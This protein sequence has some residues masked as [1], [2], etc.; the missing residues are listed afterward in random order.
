MTTKIWITRTEP[1][2]TRSADAW[3]TAGFEPV[4]A[5]LLTIESVA[6]EPTIPDDA[7]LIF[8]SAHGVRHCGVIGDDRQVYCVGNATARV[9][10][11]HGFTSVISAHGD[12]RDL[13]KI[14]D[15]TEG[16]IIHVSGS[17]VRGNIVQTL[18]DQGL[19]ARRQIVYQAKMQTSWPLDV[20]QIDAVAL[21]SPV[22]SETL[23]ALPPRHL[24]H[25][26]AY[27]LSANIAAPLRDMT[28]RIASAPNE[29]ALIACSERS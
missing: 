9:A 29:R 10:K 12:W 13:T 16:P 4:I 17:I 27:C 28:V 24:F 19:D 6:A 8:T 20:N 5:P 18:R 1:A 14:V 26:T 3:A 23:M 7:R 15:K 11:A 22:A 2:A 25:L 21:Y